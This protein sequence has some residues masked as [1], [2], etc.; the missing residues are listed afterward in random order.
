[1]ASFN[2]N[3][4]TNHLGGSLNAR[5]LFSQS[6]F[7]EFQLGIRKRDVSTNPKNVDLFWNYNI[8]IGPPIKEK[9]QYSNY[10]GTSI[11]YELDYQVKDTDTVFGVE[12]HFGMK[13]HYNSQ[14]PSEAFEEQVLFA[15][16]NAVRLS[17]KYQRSNLSELESLMVTSSDSLGL[18]IITKFQPRT[19]LSPT[20]KAFAAVQSMRP[21]DGERQMSKAYGE[22]VSLPDPKTFAAQNAGVSG[23]WLGLILFIAN[24]C[25]W[26][27][28]K[29]DSI[30][31]Q[32]VRNLEDLILEDLTN[33]KKNDSEPL[34]LD[35]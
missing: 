16:L 21:R 8:D 26:K 11:G 32:R 23:F 6:S 29:K 28:L 15:E 18:E 4:S 9:N 2:R 30:F 20:E 27:K 17:T 31:K 25:H 5:F 33:K 24:L 3:M 7:G 14:L 1:M 35:S 13:H 10:F 19:E 22:N 12:N 34:R